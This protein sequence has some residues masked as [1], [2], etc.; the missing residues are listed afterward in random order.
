MIR[1][2][3]CISPCHL[4]SVTIKPVGRIFEI[5]DSN[6]IRVNA[7]NEEKG[8]SH[9]TKTRVRGDATEQKCG[10][11]GKCRHENAEKMRL[12]CFHVTGFI[13]DPHSG[14]GVTGALPRQTLL[15]SQNYSEKT[16]SHD[17]IVIENKRFR[18]Q[19]LWNSLV[20]KA[21]GT[22]LQKVCPTK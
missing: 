3:P 15:R 4:R 16:A 13:G 19:V 8:P 21:P 12:T 22:K 10:K 20:G 14:S 2:C 9:P 6:P 1:L 7:E 17:R 5:S 11:R 18:H